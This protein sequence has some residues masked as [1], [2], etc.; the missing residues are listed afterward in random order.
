M[1]NKLLLCASAIILFCSVSHA[2]RLRIE[3]DEDVIHVTRSISSFWE[4]HK[5][6][7]ENILNKKATSKDL[8]R[9]RSSTNNLPLYIRLIGKDNANKDIEVALNY[10]QTNNAGR[11]ADLVKELSLLQA[12]INIL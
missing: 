7:R 5:E 8:E 4:Q 3:N 9:I 12:I 2:N 11:Y 6:E 10:L 1:K